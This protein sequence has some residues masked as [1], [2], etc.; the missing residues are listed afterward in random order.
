M[1]FSLW[2]MFY[3]TLLFGDIFWRSL[4]GISS[5]KDSIK[6]CVVLENRGKGVYMKKLLH[7]VHW[8]MKEWTW[9]GSY[10]L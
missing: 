2:N 6:A 8:V 3:E 5:G 9:G 1:K 7:Q 4:Y 10:F